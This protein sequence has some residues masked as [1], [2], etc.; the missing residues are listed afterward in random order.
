MLR[1]IVYLRLQHSIEPPPALV[2]LC[3]ADVWL[4]N[5]VPAVSDGSAAQ[6]ASI[7]CLLAGPVIMLGDLLQEQSGPFG[8]T[9]LSVKLP[10][11]EFEAECAV[12]CSQ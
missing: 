10:V 4:R 2:P 7:F 12:G 9:F 11:A 5:A 3:G 6:E 1:M 8:W